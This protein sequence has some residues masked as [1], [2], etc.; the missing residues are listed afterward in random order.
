MNEKVL[1]LGATGTMGHYLTE[2]LAADGCQGGRG[3]AGL[4]GF[5]PAQPAL[6]PGEK[7]PKPPP[8]WR[9]SRKIPTMPSW[10]F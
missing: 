4:C 7:T 10:I 2:K 8:L 3:F 1:I 5:F 9:K 6:Y